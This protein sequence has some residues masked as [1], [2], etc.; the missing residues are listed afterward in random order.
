VTVARRPPA[1]SIGTLR[2]VIE[3][4]DLPGRRCGPDPD[5]RWY[6][7]VHVGLARGMATEQLI[8]G[9]ADRARWAFDID[10][11]ETDDG[12]YDFGGP[13][14][15]GPRDERHLGLRWVREG[16]SGEWVVFRGAKFRLFEM[17]DALFEAASAPGRR[18]V[19]RLGLT[20][21]LG[22][23]RCA[24]VRPPVITWIVEG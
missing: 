24:T 22:W 19:G 6:E 2:V 14:V 21:E 5:G 9:D 10:L 11:R 16:E 23:P 17:D 3:G 7:N 20:D 4:S 18:L 1:R 12:A 8:P 15:H 13:H